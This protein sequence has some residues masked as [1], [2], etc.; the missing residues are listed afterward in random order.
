MADAFC[1]M[2]SP[3]LVR[4]QHYIMSA[5]ARAAACQ[6]KSDVML[7]LLMIDGGEPEQPMALFVKL[8]RCSRWHSE[9]IRRRNYHLRAGGGDGV[10]VA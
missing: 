4:H 6:S 9:N 2:V 8:W 7:C 1:V 3:A 10:T 5:L